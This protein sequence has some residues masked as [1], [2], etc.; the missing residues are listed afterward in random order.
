MD[1]SSWMKI[2]VSTAEDV[3]SAVSEAQPKGEEMERG[4]F[5]HLLDKTAQ[6]TIVES[7][8][9]TS[10]SMNLISEEGDVIIGVGGPTI[11]TD[12]IDGTTNLSRGL[13]PYVT[14]LAISENNT[15]EGVI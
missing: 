9:R 2:L 3:F 14:C 7:L 15:L 10:L 13:R 1:S 12:P 6:D 5:K 8:Q 11:I 4:P